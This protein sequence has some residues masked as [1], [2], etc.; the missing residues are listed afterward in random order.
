M[1][2]S[3]TAEIQSYFIYQKLLFT[4][5]WKLNAKQIDIPLETNLRFVS[6]GISSCFTKR[7]DFFDIPKCSWNLTELHILL[8]M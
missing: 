7:I 2:T 6:G 8:R 5:H 4:K 3:K 1:S